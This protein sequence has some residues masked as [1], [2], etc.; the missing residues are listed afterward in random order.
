MQ[1]HPPFSL[2]VAVALALVAIAAQTASA[3]DYSESV[4]GDLPQSGF[5]LPTFTLDPGSNTVSGTVAAGDPTDF[6]SFAFIVP[7]GQ[8]IISGGLTLADLTGNLSSAG[9]SLRA[10]SAFTNGGTF[11]EFVNANSPGADLIDSVPLAPGTYNLTGASL[12]DTGSSSYI[13]SFTVAVPEP[14]SLSLLAIG[15]LALL[16]RREHE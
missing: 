6:D 15:S 9:W 4:S 14:A 5:P 2:C 8:Q 1:R 12:G 3:F 7:A 16:R 13:F 10:G 11:V